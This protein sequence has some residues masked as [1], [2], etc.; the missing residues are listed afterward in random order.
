MKIAFRPWSRDA[1]A[2]AARR[3]ASRAGD[4]PR[5]GWNP[6]WL[7]PL[8]FAVLLAAAIELGL[9][10]LR[11]V[12]NVPIKQVSVNGDFRFIDK[13]EIEN[14]VLPHLGKGYFMVDLEAIRDE[15]QHQPLVH[16]VTVRRAWPDRLLVFI[17]EEVP[18]LRFG[19]DAFLNPYAEVFTPAHPLAGLELPVVTGPAGSE[20]M[21]LR[22][23]EHFAELLEPLGLGIAALSLDGKHAWR[24]RLSNGSEVLFGRRDVDAKAELLVNLFG[25]TLATER[26]RIARVDMRYSNGVALAWNNTK[27]ARV[28]AS[29][30]ATTVAAR[31]ELAG[32]H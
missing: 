22:Q 8:L 1:G 6:R 19:A 9:S 15:L 21:L 12:A 3:G 14:L 4:A 16:D 11:E 25:G 17:T 2:R 7:V 5:P 29:G 30:A 28:P 18:V 20:A 24:M 26:E 32:V 31:K 27:P 23:F 13:G 10:A